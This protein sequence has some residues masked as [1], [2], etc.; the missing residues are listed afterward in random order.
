MTQTRCLSPLSLNRWVAP[1]STLI[2]TKT[3][4]NNTASNHPMH[5]CLSRLERNL[6]SLVILTVV[7]IIILLSIVVVS[8]VYYNANND[9]GFGTTGF[10]LQ[11]RN[12]KSN[13]KNENRTGHV[14]G[15]TKTV[16]IH[17]DA[18]R[19]TNIQN[20]GS[21]KKEQSHIPFPSKY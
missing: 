7:I 4:D 5:K 6:I 9:A 8:I 11:K 14:L 10:Q 20:M 18:N 13:W 16:G 21:D 19:L 2:S 1:T 17:H 3:Q 15:G 12:I